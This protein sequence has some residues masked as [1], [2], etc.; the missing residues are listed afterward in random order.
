[1]SL[2]AFVRQHRLGLTLGVA[3]GAAVATVALAM[4][5]QQRRERALPL[6]SQL[7][8]KTLR[9]LRKS[10]RTIF[11]K[12]DADHSGTVSRK[13]LSA[14]LSSDSDLGKELREIMKESDMAP[15]FNDTTAADGV[16]KTDGESG[17][18]TGGGNLLEKSGL[19]GF[20]VFQHL[21]ENHDES[22]T[23]EEFLHAMSLELRCWEIFEHADLNGDGVLTQDEVVEAMA[24]DPEMLTL[25][26]SSGRIPMKVGLIDFSGADASSYGGL[27]TTRSGTLHIAK[28]RTV[29]ECLDLNHDGSISLPEFIDAVRPLHSSTASS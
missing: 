2:S 9:A 15:Y 25:L 21:D 28:K 12:I 18:F 23:E 7:K 27:F 17:S 5:S 19:V 22:I 3:V 8:I 10:L 16:M 11:A 6:G 26:T 29:F 24:R 1:M 13:E 4:L 14:A 20:R